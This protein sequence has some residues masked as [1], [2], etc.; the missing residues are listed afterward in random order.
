MLIINILINSINTSPDI[1]MA[2]SAT[3][4]WPIC[5]FC[6]RSKSSNKAKFFFNPQTP[7]SPKTNIKIKTKSNKMEY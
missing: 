4:Y 6:S 7:E 2:S 3:P 5:P 1:P